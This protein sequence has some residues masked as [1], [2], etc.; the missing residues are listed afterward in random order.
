[1]NRTLRS[2]AT[3]LVVAV[4]LGGIAGCSMGGDP[5]DG[6]KWK[7]EAW[8]VSSLA[9]TD[10]EITAQFAD[11]K[12]SGTSAV[13][14]YG[15]PYTAGPGDAFSVGQLASTMMAGSEPAMRAESI[16]TK[17]LGEAK[18]YKL[19]GTKLT[20]FDANGNESLIYESAK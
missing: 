7:L 12:I 11:G 9:P 8:T 18:S 1:M 15:G 13:N 20:L 5:L 2:L 19:D 17:L 14:S 3:A 6:T 16:Y 10:F 4:A